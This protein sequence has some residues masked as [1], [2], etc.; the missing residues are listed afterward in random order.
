MSKMDIEILSLV[1]IVTLTLWLL[2]SGASLSSEV[3]MTYFFL[4]LI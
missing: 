1:G 2:W 3:E 4:T